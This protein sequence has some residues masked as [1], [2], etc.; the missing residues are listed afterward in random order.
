MS[1]YKRTIPVEI[2]FYYEPEEKAT[3][4]EP[5]VAEEFS[6]ITFKIGNK[7]ILQLTNNAAWN[8]IEDVVYNYLISRENV[9]D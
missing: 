5:G 6:L 2:E 7:D 9:Y 8:K 4:F 3:E 1:T